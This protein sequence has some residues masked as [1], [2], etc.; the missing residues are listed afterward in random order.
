MPSSFSDLLTYE[1]RGLRL[2]FISGGF[3]GAD[4]TRYRRR[5]AAGG[6][7]LPLYVLPAAEAEGRARR[8]DAAHARARARGSRSA[9]S[10][11]CRRF[12][13][14]G[15]RVRAHFSPMTKIAQ[16]TAMP[17]PLRAALRI[18]GG[19]WATVGRPS[20][21]DC[22]CRWRRVAHDDVDY[23]PWAYVSR[24][25]FGSR[26]RARARYR[27]R[28]GQAGRAISRESSRVERRCG[29]GRRLITMMTPF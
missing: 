27:F 18:D 15:M 1:C 8:G 22:R 23:M 3:I 19:R 12:A 16:K 10:G 7:Y 4:N 25:C 11:R 13:A 6:F 26:R 9:R 24:G 2:G 21:T 29:R 17:P 5:Q 14:F 28:P 20:P